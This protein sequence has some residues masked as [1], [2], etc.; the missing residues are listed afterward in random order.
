MTTIKSPIKALDVK[1]EVHSMRK[2]AQRAA[3]TKSSARQFLL[4][5]G[6]YTTQGQIKPQYR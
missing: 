1:R 4:S 5:T 6:I 2:A 3:T